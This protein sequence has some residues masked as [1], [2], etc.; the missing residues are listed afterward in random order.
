MS[1]IQLKTNNK[2]NSQKM[3]DFLKSGV[4]VKV[5]DGHGSGVIVSDDGYILTNFH[6]ISE[7]QDKIEVILQDR[8]TLPAKMVRKSSNA[9][10]A[11]LKIEKTGLVPLVLSQEK[12]PEIGGRFGQL[13]HL[14]V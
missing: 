7:Q 2:L 14:K 5:E 3:N 11:L 1:L 13:A 4:T 6:V 9:D 10:L 8:T 12:D